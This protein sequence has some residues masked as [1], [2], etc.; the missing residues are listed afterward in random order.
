MKNCPGCLKEGHETYCRSCRKR[1]FGGKKVSH[2]LPFSRPAYD[3]AERA[4]P[5]ARLSISGIQTKMS[6]VLRE[7]RLEM[8]EA[9]GQYLFKPIPHG[10]F[11]HLDAVPVNEHLSMQIAR[12]VFGISVAENALVEFEGG[13]LGY[14]ARRF[15]VQEDGSKRLQEDFAQIASRSEESHG[16]NYK[17]DSSYEEIGDLIRQHVAAYRVERERFFQLVVFNYLICNGDAHL[18]NFSLLR[19]EEYGDYTMTPAYDLLNT[20]LH[21][22]DESRTALPMFKDDFTT[23]SYQANAFYAYDDIQELA[24]R[25]ELQKARFMRIMR[26]SV[27][28]EREVFSLIDRSALSEECKQLYKEGVRDASRALSYSYAES[29]SRGAVSQNIARNIS[30]PPAAPPSPLPPADD[31]A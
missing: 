18:K 11:R 12:Q 27:G 6:L 24:N 23:E 19:N 9:G 17:Y 14:L 28:K 10:E 5:G 16:K 30:N 2:V 8:T 21:V 4:A 3:Q 13:E 29:L 15:D 22:P 31:Q 1:L 7:G 20:R 26:S 25:L